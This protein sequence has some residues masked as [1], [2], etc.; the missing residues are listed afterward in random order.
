MFLKNSDTAVCRYPV[1]HFMLDIVKDQLKLCADIDFMVFICTFPG[2]RHHGLI[3]QV[4][5]SG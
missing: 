4:L 3:L 1:V 2:S 5:M